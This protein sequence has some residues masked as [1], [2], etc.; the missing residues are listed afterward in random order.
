MRRQCFGA[1]FTDNILVEDKTQFYL[2]IFFVSIGIQKRLK[3]PNRESIN[4]KTYLEV[5]KKPGFCSIHIVTA[6]CICLKNWFPGK[7]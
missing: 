6:Q 1:G 4:F 3:I 7:S 2:E 5:L